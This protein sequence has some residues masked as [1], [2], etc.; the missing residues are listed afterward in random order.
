MESKYK[1]RYLPLFYDDANEAITYISDTLKNQVAAQRL[2]DDIEKAILDRLP[3]AE[4]FMMYPSSRERE[5]QY[6]TIRISN[7]TVFYVVLNEGTCKIMEVRRLLYSRRDL[8]K[9]LQ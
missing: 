5:N 3:R 9:L 2:I 4:S 8:N 1:L 6:Y 7:F